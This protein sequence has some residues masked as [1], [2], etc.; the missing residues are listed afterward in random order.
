M[1]PEELR[2]QL[3]AELKEADYAAWIIRMKLL[4]LSNF[5]DGKQVDMQ[6]F[7]FATEH[8]KEFC[9]EVRISGNGKT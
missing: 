5:K 3:Q 7:E 2:V 4:A 6:E 8:F 1:N 9:S